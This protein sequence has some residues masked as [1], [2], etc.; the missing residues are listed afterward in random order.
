MAMVKVRKFGV[1]KARPHRK[2]KFWKLFTGLKW[3][4]AG[5]KIKYEPPI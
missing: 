3:A 5:E 2:N 4:L 1:D